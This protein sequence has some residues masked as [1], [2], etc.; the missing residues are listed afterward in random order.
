VASYGID[1]TGAAGGTG[2]ASLIGAFA[3]LADPGVDAFVFWDD[4]AGSF[5]W[6]A[7]TGG[8][9]VVSDGSSYALQ[10]GNTAR[11][12][13][14]VGTGDSP[15]FTAVNVGH[16]SDTTLERAA[17]GRLSVESV[18]I[19]RGPAT[20][21]DNA[22]ARFDAATG[23]LI[24]NSGVTID[25]GN[26]LSV[27]G[28]V[29]FS[30]AAHFT[31][32]ISPA[33]ITAD[34]NDY[35]P[36]GL[37]G[38]AVIRL[39]LDSTDRN[40]T[41]IAGGS[42]GRSLIL[43]HVS[44][45]GD[46]YLSNESASSSAAN[47]FSF[48]TSSVRLKIGQC[49]TLFYDSTS[50]RWRADRQADGELRTVQTFTAS[51]TWTAPAGIKRVR[52]RVVGGGGGG[53]G[54]ASAGNPGGG[55]GGAGG[56]VEEII[57]AAALGSTETITIGA[58]GSGGAAGSNGTAGGTSSFGAHCSATGGALGGT[59]GSGGAGGSGSGGHVNTVGG[60]GHSASLDTGSTQYGG[61]G[62][63]SML[64]GGAAS[65]A[66]ATAN[67]GGGGGGGAGNSPG[68]NGGTGFIIVEEF[69]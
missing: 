8:G 63:T 32:V 21:T 12:T 30:A 28:S 34:Q 43:H 19:V 11:T 14:G 40:I 61:A 60:S 1:R 37:S 33:Q 42:S 18:A 31:G 10:T 67:T 15:Q 46:V 24:Q 13:I 5:D 20:A 2:T 6:F 69:Y 3:E 9:V 66:S 22:I 26:N 27:P 65:G 29:T 45:S 51:G 48:D 41:G 64:G 52:V 59:N 23:D 35:N 56:Y 55:G 47:R 25:D 38:A 57:G 7:A 44:G 54:G 17:A 49:V 39:T 36:T 4:S 53:G 62:G 50:S 16:A 68:G 58:A